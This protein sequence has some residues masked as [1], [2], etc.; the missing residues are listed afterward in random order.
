MTPPVAGLAEAMAAFHANDA[1]AMR[2]A[3]LRYPEVR[4][5]IN[6]PLGP[7]DAP[8][9]IYASSR[10]M[11]DVLVEAGADIN[12]RSQWW[13]GGFGLLDLA[14]PDVATHAIERGATLD[15]H[16]AARLGLADTLRGMIAARPDV[17]HA[18]GGD[19]QTPLHFASTIETADLLLAAGAD[20]NARDVDHESTPAQYMVGQRQD[21]A[22]HL[23]ANGSRTDLLMTAAL[24]D[25]ERTRQHLD[26]DSSCIAMRVN[27][28]WF[29]MS[30]PK[31]GGTIYNWTL[32]FHA[33]AH[34]VAKRF[35]HSEV[36]DL[37]FERTAPVAKVVEACWIE[38]EPLA[39]R[40]RAAVPDMA[41]AL[42]DRQ[43]QLLAHAARNNKTDAV[44]LMLECGVPVDAV[45]QHLGT[46]L[47]WAAFHGNADM[48]RE[49]LRFKPPLEATDRDFKAPPIGWAMYGSEHGWYVSSGSHGQVVELLL[50]AGAK[51]P[52][53]I[54]GAAAVRD[55]LQRS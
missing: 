35:G 26:A 52:D 2:G 37:L 32:D 7:F 44:R 25:L 3:L 53:T 1:A 30:N 31:A 38:D 10:E 47:H 18:R 48:V 54:G 16:S 50:Q 36:L 19:G 39:R 40:F 5:K 21:V 13:A 46:P 23:V 51:R 33:S 11:L 9:I 4:A 49:I 12:A 8:V 6:E 45:G 29:P 17:V 41:G 15:A 43:R 24:G 28:D 55:V 42:D 27:G 22:R 14:R 34:E 20:V